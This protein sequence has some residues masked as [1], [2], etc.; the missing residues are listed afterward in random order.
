MNFYYRLI[1]ERNTTNPKLPKLF[2][3]NSFFYTQLSSKGYTSV[4][5]WTKKVKYF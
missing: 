4:R 2:M 5:R 3:F 1:E